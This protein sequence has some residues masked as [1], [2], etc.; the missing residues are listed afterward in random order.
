[1]PCRLQAHRTRAALLAALVL[2]AGTALAEERHRPDR[3]TSR[4]PGDRDRPP[5]EDRGPSGFSAA[6]EPLTAAERRDPAVRQFWSDKCVQQ[7]A[8]G[9]GHT[10]DCENPAY[11]GSHPPRWRPYYGGGYR[12]DDGYGYRPR[13]RPY[14]RFP[15]RGDAVRG[16]APSGAFGGYDRR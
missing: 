9:W 11:S 15:D 8:R 2:L 10:G 7:R 14:R 4:H 5:A 12:D 1:M 16:S 6:R 3:D 13:P